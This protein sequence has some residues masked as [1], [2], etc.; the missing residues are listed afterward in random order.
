[1]HENPA[2]PSLKMER[3]IQ[4]TYLIKILSSQEQP[5]KA[6]SVPKL[7]KFTKIKE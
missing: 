1:M 4:H 5:N 3:A 7:T 6:Q 2:I